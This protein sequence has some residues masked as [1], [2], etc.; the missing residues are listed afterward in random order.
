MILMKHLS[1]AAREPLAEL[2]QGTRPSALCAHTY[3]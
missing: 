1:A 2:G 3:G